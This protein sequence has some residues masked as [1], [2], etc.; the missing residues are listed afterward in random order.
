MIDL[1]TGNFIFPELS[2]SLLPLYC[3]NDFIS[4]FPRDRIEKIRDMK[5]GYIWYD[6]REKIYETDFRVPVWMCFNPQNQ[7][8]VIH[9]YPQAFDAKVHREWAAWTEENMK[10]DKKYCED[11]LSNYC[12]LVHGENDFTWGTIIAFF[13]PRSASCGIE[14]RY[15]NKT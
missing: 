1:R 13:D 2:I 5:N 10:K 4:T 15:T 12:S 8:E 14:I 7:L 11:W 3:R 9:F 6:V